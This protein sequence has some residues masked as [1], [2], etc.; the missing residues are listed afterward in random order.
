MKRLATQIYESVREGKLV[1]PFSPK[2]VRTVCPDWAYKTY[3]TF[4]AKHKL[5]NT[6]E[7]ELFEQVGPGLY[8]TLK[9]P[10]SDP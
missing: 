7:T 5:G 3:S 8:R 4:L 9:P 2:D 1:E 6:K 10:P